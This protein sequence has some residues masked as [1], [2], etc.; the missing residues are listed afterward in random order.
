[1]IQKQICNQNNYILIKF[2]NF[3][4]KDLGKTCKLYY[5]DPKI[6]LQ[7]SEEY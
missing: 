6:D 3:K 1:M 2:I 4:F 5:N 7:S